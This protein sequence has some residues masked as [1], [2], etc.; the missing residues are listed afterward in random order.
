MKRACIYTEDERLFYELS[1][2]LSEKGY[3]ISENEDGALL[4]V[5]LDSCPEKAKKGARVL[6]L[7]REGNRRGE[8][9]FLLRPFTFD[10]FF[11]ALEELEGKNDTL[12]LSATE[13][14]LFSLLK[15]A[16]GKSVPREAL[17][18]GV[19][20]EDGNDRLLNLYI[21]YLREKLEKDGR[22]RIYSARGKGYFYKC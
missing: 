20:G 6:T 2:L 5:D 22:R 16:N 3:D 13:A 17:I 19:W 12:S 8:A 14:K 4:L 1:L 7:S 9:P 15:A 11:H 21:H 10:A 18:D